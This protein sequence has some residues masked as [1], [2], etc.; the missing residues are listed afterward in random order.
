MT[1]QDR[2]RDGIARAAS[3]NSAL[4]SSI[5]AE[6]AAALD[7]KNAE[8][9]RVTKLYEKQIAEIVHLQGRILESLPVIDAARLLLNAENN[10]NTY[11][12]DD[13]SMSLVPIDDLNLIDAA[14][15][16]LQAALA[17]LDKNND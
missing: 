2:L 3:G 4:W 7:A 9:E 8:I 16:E 1:L 6:S 11:D 12:T 13:L 5:M 15:E 14:T 17:A 10:C